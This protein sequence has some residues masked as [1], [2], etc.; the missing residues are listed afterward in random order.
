MSGIQIDPIEEQRKSF[1]RTTIGKY[2][3]DNF[4][5]MANVPRDEVYGWLHNGEAL[6][7]AIFG[8]I[9]DV[10][11]MK[12]ARPTDFASLPGTSRR[13]EVPMTRTGASVVAP[14][15]K[16]PEAPAVEPE[17]PE[18]EETSPPAD[19]S[20]NLPV[21]STPEPIK[22]KQKRAKAVTNETVSPKITGDSRNITLLMPVYKSLDPNTV[23][24]MLR[25]WDRSRMRFEM[26]AG[27][28]MIARSRNHLA[29][30]F[31]KT[32]SE[33]SFWVDDD[34]ILPCGS[35]ELFRF[36]T[37]C[38]DPINGANQQHWSFRI[39]DNF[40]SFSAPD[41]LISHGKSIVSGIY[42][43]RWQK[44]TIT[45]VFGDGPKTSLPADQ[46]H[47]VDFTGFGCIAVHRKV[48]EDIIATFP[49]VMKKDAPGN[50]SGFF[51]PIQGE[52]GRMQG[53]DQSFCWRAKQA[54]HTTFLDLALI[55]GH[56]G[57]IC[58]GL[59]EA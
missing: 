19:D 6:S 2:G 49:E 23:A 17:S 52:D 35:P 20:G 45:A 54:G 36:L 51:T 22:W 57:S 38:Y 43:D 29:T 10:F 28:A 30:R 42:F 24:T 9:Q 58:C 48:Y 44:N 32:D 33:W 1:I 41:R 15:E 7:D 26:R 3:E 39:P 16:H 47:P 4:F 5:L 8:K 37:G 25:F 21:V 55:C 11:P 56:V 50:E 27:D 46:L 34:V 31:L 12:D 18:I 40:L 14:G 59:P 13:G 53:E